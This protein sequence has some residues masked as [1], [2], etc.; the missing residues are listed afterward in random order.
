MKRIMP[1][2]QFGLANRAWDLGLRFV[3]WWGNE[4]LLSIPPGVRRHLLRQHEPFSVRVQDDGIQ[5]RSLEDP[6]GSWRLLSDTQSDLRF[7]IDSAALLLSSQLV[8][9]RAV[10]LPHAAADTLQETTSFQIGRITPFALQDVYHVARLTSRDRKKKNVRVE[11][12]VVPRTVLEQLLVQVEA[13]GIQPSAI[14]VDGDIAQPPFDFLPALG[15]RVEQSGAAPW[16]LAIIASLIFVLAFPF[17]AAYRIHTVAQASIAEATAA[18]KIARK[19]SALQNQLD[20]LIASR[21]F[22]PDRLKG[23]RAIETLDALSRLIPDSAWLFRLEI[24]PEEATISGFSSDLPALLQQL[25]AAPFA[26]PELTSPVVQGR[27][28]DQTRFDIRVRY[29]GSS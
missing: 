28:G 21:S 22:L 19:A 17:V 7:K 15:E 16:R 2:M 10:E 11:V 5:I 8:L 12:A 9:R 26:A 4:L 24:R 1:S 23:P 13:G 29:R 27:T 14:L 25:A 20:T 18:A 3:R 6:A